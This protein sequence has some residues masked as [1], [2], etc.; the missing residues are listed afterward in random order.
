VAPDAWREALRAL[1]A[2]GLDTALEVDAPESARRISITDDEARVGKRRFEPV[3]ADHFGVD[4]ESHWLALLH[5]VD[6]PRSVFVVPFGADQRALA[7][8]GAERLY[9]T[10]EG[11]ARE[12]A[13][14]RARPV[15]H[16]RLLD[17]VEA[18]F[19]LAML[20]FFF[21]LLPGGSVLVAWMLGVG[22]QE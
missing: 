5:D 16:N 14:A 11:H 17:W 15:W 10:V 22:L 19:V 9:R 4:I 1:A 18:H 7:E 2:A 8:Q 13:A 3:Y 20:L 6:H 12:R 21:V